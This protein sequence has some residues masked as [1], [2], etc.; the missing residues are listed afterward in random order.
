[1]AQIFA[2]EEEAIKWVFLNT[3]WAVKP[4][5]K[6]DSIKFINPFTSA[7]AHNVVV[8]TLGKKLFKLQEETLK[9]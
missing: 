1:M 6:T 3:P 4:K 5:K 9:K 8:E 2:S 7:H